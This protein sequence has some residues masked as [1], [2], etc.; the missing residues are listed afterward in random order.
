MTQKWG[1]ACRVFSFKI[2][3]LYGRPGA[4]TDSAGDAKHIYRIRSS[5]L[6]GAMEYDCALVALLS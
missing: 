3:L 6:R 5:L 2:L 1:V 4:A